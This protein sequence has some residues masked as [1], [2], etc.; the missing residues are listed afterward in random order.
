MTDNV[1]DIDNEDSGEG[2]GITPAGKVSYIINPED[3]RDNEILKDLDK[4]SKE[5]FDILMDIARDTGASPKDRVAAAK[6]VVDSRNAISDKISQE[7]LKRMVLESQAML[8]SLPKM[9]NV[10]ALDDDEDTP[11]VQFM[12]N[13]ILDVSTTNDLGK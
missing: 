13:V 5:A 1:E 7:L 9:K 3:H 11:N 8:K 6:T 4:K 2:A 12:P 10:S